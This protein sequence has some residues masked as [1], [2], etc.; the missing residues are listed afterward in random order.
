MMV[1]DSDKVSLHVT[2]SFVQQIFFLLLWVSIFPHLFVW[3]SAVVFL[4]S[5]EVLFLII[6]APFEPMLDLGGMS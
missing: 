4:T 5:S 6:R 3:F 2:Q 1:V